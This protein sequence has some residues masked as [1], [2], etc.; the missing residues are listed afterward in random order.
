M[1]SLRMNRELVN[2]H[3]GSL[4]TGLT[5]S[6]DFDVERLARDFVY[7]RVVAQFGTLVT[8]SNSNFCC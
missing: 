8:F 7:I 5:R 4:L 6:E 3:L 2:G 1:R